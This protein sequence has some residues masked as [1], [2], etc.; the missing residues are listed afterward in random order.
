MKV[1]AL[2]GLMISVSL[3]IAGGCAR[4]ASTET[5]TVDYYVANTE[6][7]AAMLQQCASNPGELRDSPNCVNAREATRR[8]DRRSLRDLPALGLSD[9]HAEKQQKTD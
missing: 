5:K 2:S 9:S 3:L 4:D 7:R 8:V 6:E 1:A